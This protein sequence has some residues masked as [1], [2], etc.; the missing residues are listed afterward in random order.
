MVC[1]S[2]EAAVKI[3]E[4]REHSDDQLVNELREIERRL[5]DMRTQGATEKIEAT[6]ELKKLRRDVA[7]IKTVIRERELKAQAATA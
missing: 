2:A 6:S 4:I 7:R 3:K 5:F 1:D